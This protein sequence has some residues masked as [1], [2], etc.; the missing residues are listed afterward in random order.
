MSRFLMAGCACVALLVGTVRAAGQPQE[1]LA[2]QLGALAQASAYELDAAGNVVRFG[3]SNHGQ[4]YKDKSVPPKPGLQD[5]DMPKLLAFPKLQGVFFET[6][7]ISDKGY[8]VLT[9]LPELTDVR[10]HYV[11]DRMTT[12]TVLSSTPR[13]PAFGLVVNRLQMPLKILEFKHLFSVKGTVI[14]QLKPQPELEKLELDCDFCGSSAVPFICQS[15]K[16]RNLQLHRQTMTDADMQKI[17]AALPRLEVLVLRPTG[18]AKGGDPIT[19][20]TLRGLKVHQH[21]KWLWLGISWNH[22]TYAGGLEYL[23]SIP[24]LEYIN[25]DD[26]KL[27]PEFE[28][29]LKV[30]PDLTLHI[31]NHKLGKP[32]EIS[33]QDEH[34]KWGIITQ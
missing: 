26:P 25:C 6:Q 21:L 30:R 8:E 14:N 19:G 32:R 13:S 27:K 23:A 31:G 18:R 20:Q 7:P 22:L 33:S 28:E 5:A 34:Y 17:F 9:Q 11:N 3:V 29:L 16:V 10:F 24:T 12:G 1:E 2:K 15:P 4:F